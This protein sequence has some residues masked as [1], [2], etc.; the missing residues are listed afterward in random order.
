MRSERF[1]LLITDMQMPIMSGEELL[2]CARDSHPGTVRVA[3]SGHAEMNARFRSVALAHRYLAKPCTLVELRETL[4]RARDVQNDL[5]DGELLAAVARDVA[6]PPAPKQY[7]RLM[8]VLADGD[9]SIA[10]IAAIVEEDDALTAKVLQVANSAFLGP[11]REVTVVVQAIATIGL[12]ALKALTLT[13]GA[14]QAF[15]EATRC[16]GFDRDRHQRH[17][18]LTGFI[19][20]AMGR[21]PRARD[22]LFTYGVLHDIG[23]LVLASRMPGRYAPVL[24][25][26]ADSERQAHE[27]EREQ[28]LPTHGAVGAALLNLWNLPVP[29]VEAV[30]WHHDTG[31]L[32]GGAWSPA[33]AVHV[34]D[35]LAHEQAAEAGIESGAGS[36]PVDED[37][38]KS[39]GVLDELVEWRKAAAA[40]ARRALRTG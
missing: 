15:R 1:D 26:A 10:A 31:R 32:A 25:I 4:R 5:A 29:V 6:L 34:A 18:L 37:L 12:N 22:E 27:V 13:F 16:P 24:R 9:T 3:L 7:A 35:A 19:G 23:K 14:F 28:G 17:A 20:A 21:T 2:A 11:A 40:E 39:L 38:L 30:R 36:P 8:R 33:A